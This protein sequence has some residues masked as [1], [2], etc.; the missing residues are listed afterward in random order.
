[1]APPEI[2]TRSPCIPLSNAEVMGRE[3]FKY[4]N[5]ETTGFRLLA[6]RGSISCALFPEWCLS[7]AVIQSAL[8]E[9]CHCRRLHVSLAS[10]LVGARFKY[11]DK[12][13]MG[14]SMRLPT[15]C[16][17]CGERDSQAHALGY[18]G[19]T[20]PPTAPE[21]L[22]E[23]LWK[24]AVTAGAVNPHASAPYLQEWQ[25]NRSWIWKL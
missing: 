12:L 4:E 14:G 13:S 24:L 1:M 10:F 19:E 22:I 8:L 15:K 5:D 11:F 21:D 23:F 9:L 6:A 20:P 16:R 18:I 17:Q 25:R 3:R 2:I 7:K